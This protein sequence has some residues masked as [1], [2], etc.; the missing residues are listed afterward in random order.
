MNW[1]DVAAKSPIWLNIGGSGDCHPTPPY[2]GYVSVDLEPIGEWS[3]AHDLR[4]PIP[5]PDGSVQRILTEHFLEHIE[6]A[7]IAAFLADAWRLLEPGGHVRFAVPDYHSP[8]NRK[9]RAQGY[10]PTHTD[11]VCFPTYETM[12]G[13]VDASPFTEVRFYQYWDGETFVDGDIDYS[14]GYVKRTKDNDKRN[15]R[16]GAGKKV[17]GVLRDGAWMLSRGFMF[18]RNELSVQRGHP[19][20]M[21]SIVCDLVKPG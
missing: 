17:L 13:I 9:Y 7:E 20:R 21:T 3:V 11:H 16:R 8:R 10:D 6:E 18:T 4:T 14:L 12:K 15:F 2:E 1:E 19:L 5:L